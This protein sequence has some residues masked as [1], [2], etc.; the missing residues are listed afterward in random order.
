MSSQLRFRLSDS[1]PRKLDYRLRFYVI[2][3]K[4]SRVNDTQINEKNEQQRSGRSRVA[5]EEVW[6][7]E[8]HHSLRVFVGHFSVQ[9]GH[10]VINESVAV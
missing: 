8:A 7:E 9:I 10:G 6:A 1:A 4:E 2:D 5:M 3:S